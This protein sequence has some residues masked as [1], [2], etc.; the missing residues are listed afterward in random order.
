MKNLLEYLPDFMKALESQLTEDQ[1]RWGD[2]WT[3]RSKEGQ[4][5][6]T[7]EVYDNYFDQFENAG[8][9][10]PWL[11]IVGGALICWVREQKH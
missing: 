10:I 9:P 4:E 7:R 5:M 3:K 2:T 1:K 11:K 6:R 8:I